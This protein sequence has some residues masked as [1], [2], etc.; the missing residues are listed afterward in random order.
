[1]KLDDLVYEVIESQPRA[2]DFFAKTSRWDVA[3]ALTEEEID[4]QRYQPIYNVLYPLPQQFQMPTDVR[5]RL[6][7]M[8]VV[9]VDDDETGLALTGC[10]MD[11]TWEICETYMRL[12][13]Y[14]PVALCRLPEMADRGC[15]K[16]DRA[17]VAACMRS[18]D[19]V[20]KR[21]R[22]TYEHLQRI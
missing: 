15:S 5:R 20:V 7:N 6:N 16:L 3:F 17:I 10:G 8:T 2:Y 9:R 14:P 19:A 13:Y 22:R 12:G 1:M 11:F 18:V 4:A 21:H